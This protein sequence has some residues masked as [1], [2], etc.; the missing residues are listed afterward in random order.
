MPNVDR[1]QLSDLR[2]Y[3]LLDVHRVHALGRS[4]WD[5]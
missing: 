1:R 3:A 2:K 4:D 5:R